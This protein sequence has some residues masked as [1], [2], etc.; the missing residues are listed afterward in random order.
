MS[1]IYSIKF[2]DF[3]QHPDFEE[4]FTALEHSFKL[5]GVDFYLIG[6]I[7]KNIWI[8]KIHQIKPSRTT[9]D[10]DLAILISNK[11]AFEELKQHIIKEYPFAASQSNAFLLRWRE[12]YDV[13]LL[14]FGE[15]ENADAKVVVDGSGFTSID[16]PGFYEI[17]LNDL[18][19]VQIE[20]KTEFKI[21][22]LVGIVILKLLA[23]ND[24]PE[25][26]GGDITDIG[27]ILFHYFD[28]HDTFIYE[29]YAYLF[30]E[31]D[32][33]RQLA[34]VV[35]GK[36]IKRVVGSNA[37]LM[38]RIVSII[39]DDIQRDAASLLGIK[40]AKHFNNTIDEHLALFR[41]VLIGLDA[42]N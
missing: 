38:Q 16:V 12:R 31:Y 35:M 17:Y 4:M 29:R 42:S 1:N 41:C 32:D 13:D 21:T 30:N 10:F 22:S 36:E 6:A 3:R 40:L 18:Q 2:E 9:K 11:Q 5:Y 27:D 7:A 37:V 14:P 23:W 24:R 26:R 25:A 19:N 28:M 15:I 33:L 39:R 8:D 34:A 20:N